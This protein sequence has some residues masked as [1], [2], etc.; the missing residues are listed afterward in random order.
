MFDPDSGINNDTDMYRGSLKKVL[1]NLI[2]MYPDAYLEFINSLFTTVTPLEQ[3][4]MSE[5]REAE[6]VLSFVYY[7]GDGCNVN[8]QSN[9]YRSTSAVDL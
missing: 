7:F 9:E 3:F 4:A 5:W 8:I 1:V 6:A 2:K